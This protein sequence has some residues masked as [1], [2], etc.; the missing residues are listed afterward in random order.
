MKPT[1]A[2]FATLVKPFYDDLGTVTKLKDEMRFNRDWSLHL[3]V[4]A[5]GAPCVGWVQAVSLYIA[6]ILFSQWFYLINSP[7]I[8]EPM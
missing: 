5:D 1:D 7:P 6:L 3:Q 2:E 4:V 8:L